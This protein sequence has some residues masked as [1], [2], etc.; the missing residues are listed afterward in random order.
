MATTLTT[1]QLEKLTYKFK[2]FAAMYNAAIDRYTILLTRTHTDEDVKHYK[3]RI[4][5]KDRDLDSYIEGFNDGTGADLWL[6]YNREEDDNGCGY[7]HCTGLVI[8][9]NDITITVQ[10]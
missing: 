5:D 9:G 3:K 7:S 8:P 4:G 10:A 2:L 6:T 1:K